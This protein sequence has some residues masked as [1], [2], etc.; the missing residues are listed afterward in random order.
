[1]EDP[2]ALRQEVHDLGLGFDAV[3]SNTFQDQPGQAHSY[4]HG[5]LSAVSA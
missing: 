4:R 5:S 3:N 2:V 1:V